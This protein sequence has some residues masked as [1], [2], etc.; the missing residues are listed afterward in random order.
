MLFR[1]TKD[2][3]KTTSQLNDELGDTKS[4]ALRVADALDASTAQMVSDLKAA[5][6]AAKALSTA[7][8]PELTAKISS[9]RVDEFVGRLRQAGVSFDDI[10]SNADRFAESLHKMDAASGSLEDVHQAAARTGEELGKSKSVM[11]NFVGNA[12]QELPGISDAF[13]PLNMAVGQFAEYATEGDVTLSS[14]LK[15][16]GPIAAIGAGFAIFSSIMGELGRHEKEVKEQA[17]KL[18]KIGRAHV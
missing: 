12:V 2:L 4:H 8:G 5:D 10:T 6:K 15:T 7:L 16:A 18:V 13:G 9:A 11:A 14:F 17:E 3:S 1:S